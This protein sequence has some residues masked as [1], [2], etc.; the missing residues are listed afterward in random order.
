MHAA[1][2]HRIKETLEAASALNREASGVIGALAGKLQEMAK[3]RELWI[4]RCLAEKEIQQASHL[5]KRAVH[6]RFHP[7]PFSAA[8]AG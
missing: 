1:Y 7:T 8:A 5:L 6:E 3:D 2:V 4:H